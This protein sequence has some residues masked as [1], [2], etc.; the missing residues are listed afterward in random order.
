[1]VIWKIWCSWKKRRKITSFDY[2]TVGNS[3]LRWQLNNIVIRWGFFYF[4]FRFI[5][6]IHFFFF[7]FFDFF[8]SRNSIS[9]SQGEAMNENPFRPPTFSAI[10]VKSIHLRIWEII[11]GRK[12]FGTHGF[13]SF[14]FLFC[15]AFIVFRQ[16][17]MNWFCVL[18]SYFLFLKSSIRNMNK[19][20]NPVHLTLSVSML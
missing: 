7:L 11:N 9:L 1:M 12:H 16:K 2:V 4:S 20:G 3:F 13:S 18:F 10:D 6:L 5:F 15:S 8:F 17:E 14:F 19:N